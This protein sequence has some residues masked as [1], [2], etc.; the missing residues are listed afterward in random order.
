MPKSVCRYP[1]P[2]LRNI[3][4]RFYGWKKTVFHPTHFDPFHR[5]KYISGAITF[6]VLSALK[7]LKDKLSVIHRDVKPSNILLN[8]N[9]DSKIEIKLCDF[10]IAG[11]LINSMA[12]TNVGCKP[13]MAPERI[14]QRVG[15]GKPVVEI[16]N[17]AF[18]EFFR[19]R[20]K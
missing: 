5:L 12:K 11:N 19:V 20:S 15:Q 18:I 10:G 7:Y 3:A 16:Q 17:L 6:A 2:F 8:K 14:E 9:S 1:S 4:H 13:Y